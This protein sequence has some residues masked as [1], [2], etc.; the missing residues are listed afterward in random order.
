[1][2]EITRNPLELEDESR[3]Y[4]DDIFNGKWLIHN[5]TPLK[6][7]GLEKMTAT[8][9]VLQRGHGGEVESYFTFEQGKGSGEI[10][11]RDGKYYAI[12]QLVK[13]TAS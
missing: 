11:R 6:I 7:S 3:T 2:V 9:M 4:L 10:I 13:T 1:M 8:S 5:P 12:G